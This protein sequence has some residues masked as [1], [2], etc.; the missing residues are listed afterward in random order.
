MWFE[1][2]WPPIGLTLNAWSKVG[3]IVWEG[4]GVALMVYDEGQ[5]WSVQSQWHSQLVFFLFP[6]LPPPISHC[7]SISALS[8]TPLPHDCGIRWNLSAAVWPAAILSPAPL[9]PFPH[10][11]ATE[12]QP[13]ELW[14]RKWKCFISCLGHA[15]SS[16]QEKNTLSL[17]TLIQQNSRCHIYSSPCL[18]LA[19]SL[20]KQHSLWTEDRFSSEITWQDVAGQRENTKLKTCNRTRLIGFTLTFV[21]SLVEFSPYFREISSLLHKEMRRGF[22]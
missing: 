16:Q 2:E 14:A 1:W 17:R 20:R 4:L 8:P 15:I 3:G 21:A 9:A 11:M 6:P 7:L 18:V 12:S 5:L 19:A 22:F 13:L 10:I